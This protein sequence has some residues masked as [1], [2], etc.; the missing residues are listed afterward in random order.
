MALSIM[1]T[2]IIT[3]MLT[4][5]VNTYI[6]TPHPQKKKK[7]KKKHEQSQL[8]KTNILYMTLTYNDQCAEGFFYSFFF[9]QS[10]MH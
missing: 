2:T 3:H 7:K 8:C 6:N 10:R 4:F 9:S 1:R 5:I